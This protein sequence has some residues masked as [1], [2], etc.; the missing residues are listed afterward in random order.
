MWTRRAVELLEQIKA[1]AESQ[2][3]IPPSWLTLAQQIT[4]SNAAVFDA[5]HQFH[6][7][8]PGIHEV[9][10]RQGLLDG[11]WCLDPEEQLSPGQVAAIDGVCERYPELTD[12]EFVQ[13]NRD[14]WLA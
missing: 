14:R 3:P 13:A 12:D 1:L 4:E 11:R 2:S 9:L 6:G 10:R 8:I 5:A 7:C